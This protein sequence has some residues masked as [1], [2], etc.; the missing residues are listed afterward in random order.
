MFSRMTMRWKLPAHAW[1]HTREQEADRDPTNRCIISSAW[2]WLEIT[3]TEHWHLSFLPTCIFFLLTKYRP[4]PNSLRLM[5]TDQPI[6]SYQVILSASEYYCTTCLNME[7]HAGRAAALIKYRALHC[8]SSG[9][10]NLRNR[11]KGGSMMN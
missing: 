10:S 5:G 2:I 1:K 3:P 4:L 6:A 8:L 9:D 7:E 11:C